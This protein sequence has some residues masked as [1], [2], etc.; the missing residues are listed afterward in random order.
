MQS[1]KIAENDVLFLSKSAINDNL[2]DL[3][4]DI[5]LKHPSDLDEKGALKIS[6]SQFCILLK[7]LVFDPSL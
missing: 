2:R 1:Q 3:V 4:D 6:K 7:Q 5:F